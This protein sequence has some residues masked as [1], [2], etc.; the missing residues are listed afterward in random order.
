MATKTAAKTNP[1]SV[2]NSGNVVESD[3][4]EKAKSS[5]KTPGVQNSKAT[6]TPVV[7][8]TKAKTATKRTSKAKEAGELNE[9]KVPD[10]PEAKDFDSFT[11]DQL[12]AFANTFNKISDDGDRTSVLIAYDDSF[13]R[14]E[15]VNA[16]V[17]AVNID[18]TKIDQC[19]A[20]SNQTMINIPISSIKIHPNNP[21]QPIDYI[22]PELFNSI[23]KSGGMIGSL[24]VVDSVNA[25]L[26]EDG[27]YYVIDGNRSFHN[28][29]KFVKE[30]L[31]D[32]EEEHFIDVSLRSY[33]GTP[34]EIKNQIY[35][36]LTSVN[37]K[38]QQFTVINRLDLVNQQLADGKKKTQIAEEMGVSSAMISQIVSLNLL[39]KDILLRVHYEA[40]KSR[41]SKLPQ[42]QLKDFGVPFKVKDNEVIIE[43][44][45]FK[46]ALALV[47]VIPKKP[48][49]Y[50]YSDESKFQEAFNAWSASKKK[51]TDYFLDEKI[52]S[53]A[54][55]ESEASFSKK[56]TA[57]LQEVYIL[58]GATT[59]PPVDVEEDSKPSGKV[60]P[61][62]K[63][64]QE[65]PEKKERESSGEPSGVDTQIKPDKNSEKSNDEDSV[66]E[67]K[68]KK[69][70]RTLFENSET[71][72][73]M[74]DDGNIDFCAGWE[75]PIIAA[76]KRRDNKMIDLVKQLI[77][78]GIIGEIDED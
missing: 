51:I 34:K 32:K 38:A 47:A 67:K 9:I 27:M 72:S 20:I 3:A 43:G 56:L 25:G 78:Y 8:E 4:V 35:F 42:Q 44:I 70:I 64:K 77:S 13:N 40:T 60:E 69:L 11:V 15:L 63:P 2:K 36:E 45:T 30:V 14:E 62:S 7:A 54:V 12:K 41:L 59:P 29:V 76:L 53:M 5:K 75:K 61:P 65:A 49:R 46:N 55:N 16:I 10:F 21:R 66:E 31:L 33:T 28:Y 19:Y 18:N 74:I 68:K 39:P 57:F 17:E 48:A 37:D 26:D 24:V 22:D 58:P 1:K 71:I 6:S 50:S 52:I 73:K 23:K